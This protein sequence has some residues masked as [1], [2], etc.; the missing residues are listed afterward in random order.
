MTPTSAAIGSDEPPTQ[1]QRDQMEK[2]PIVPGSAGVDLTAADNSPVH[3]VPVAIGAIAILV[4]LPTGCTSYGATGNDLFRDRPKTSLT[5]LEDVFRGTATTWGDLIPTLEPNTAACRQAPIQRLVRR[6]SSGT[7][8]ALR[9][10][11]AKIDPANAADWKTRAGGASWPNE[12]TAA[13]V[14]KADTDGG[15]SLTDKGIATP[16]TIGYVD[17]ATARA[18]GSQAYTWDAA[19]PIDRTFWLPLQSS[20]TD[21]G[22]YFDPQSDAQ[23]Y[24]LNNAAARGANCSAVDP[25]RRPELDAR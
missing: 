10:L 4:H 24:K 20:T 1:S 12:A 8:F 2:G 16:G 25:T 14:V 6:D 5:A 3:V 17:L 7:T 22:N 13:V 18:R 19:Q 11:L 21:T 15:S 23:G 9:Q